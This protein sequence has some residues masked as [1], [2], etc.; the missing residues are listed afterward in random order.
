MPWEGLPNKPKRVKRLKRVEAGAELVEGEC[1]GW[2][3][4]SQAETSPHQVGKKIFWARMG[5]GSLIPVQ[6]WGWGWKALSLS[7][8]PLTLPELS[9]ALALPMGQRGAAV[10]TFYVGQHST[11]VFLCSLPAAY[12]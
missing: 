5:W 1:E 2:E 11:L 3:D 9:G 7:N 12:N 6:A 4:G 10:Q 8:P